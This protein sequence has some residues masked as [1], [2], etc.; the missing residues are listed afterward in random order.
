MTVTWAG[1]LG[2]CEKGSL[3]LPPLG[4]KVFL[5]IFGAS[6]NFYDTCPG[7]LELVGVRSRRAGCDAHGQ[8]NV[9]SGATP[10]SK[11]V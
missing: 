7:G 4:D 3:L 1:Q 10:R 9:V 2:G 8:S 6:G 11:L 5:S